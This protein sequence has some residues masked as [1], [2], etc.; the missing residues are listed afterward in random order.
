MKKK[1]EIRKKRNDAENENLRLRRFKMTKSDFRL[2]A[3]LGKGGFGEVYLA[4]KKDTGEILALKK[5]SRKKFIHKNET[6]KVKRERNV[7]A[8]TN[9]PWLIQLKY[10]FKDP[11][12]I[13]LA[14]EFLPGGDLKNFI[15]S[16][17]MFF[18]RT[19]KILF[20]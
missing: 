9:S 7:M 10:A 15:G 14:M 6:E 1:D 5:M 11:E 12:S 8:S 19:C 16:C 4:R 18:V 3:I 20:Y 17:W 2:L 13:Y